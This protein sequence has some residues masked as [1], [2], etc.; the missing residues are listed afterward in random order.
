MSHMLR[1]SSK[2]L[3][4]Q[5]QH[6]TRLALEHALDMPS[7]RRCK[8]PPWQSQAQIYALRSLQQ[9]NA[10]FEREPAAKNLVAWS[11][12][13]LNSA[14]LQRQH[15]RSDPDEGHGVDRQMK[16]LPAI[17]VDHDRH[18]HCERQAL[19]GHLRVLHQVQAKGDATVMTVMRHEASASFL[20][21]KEPAWVHISL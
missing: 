18:P 9:S 15:G 16:L 4:H 1:K 10:W 6:F 19:L 12:G 3:S 14:C 11:A 13:A 7:G 2:R 5:G 21:S 20:H 17:F 8:C